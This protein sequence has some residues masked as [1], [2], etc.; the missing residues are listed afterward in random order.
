M[1]PVVDVW[2]NYNSSPCLILE[3][4]QLLGIAS[5]GPLDEEA[6]TKRERQE[7]ASKAA[8]AGLYDEV[9]AQIDDDQELASRLTY[10]EQEMYTVEERSK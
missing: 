8:L 10:E 5:I 7:E 3:S 6:R 9:Q 1:A 2:Q 4:I